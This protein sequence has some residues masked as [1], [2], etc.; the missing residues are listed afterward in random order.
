VHAEA[1]RKTSFVLRSSAVRKNRQISQSE[2]RVAARNR[3]F[4]T[5]L[6]TLRKGA[7]YTLGSTPK[8][9]LLYAKIGSA[10]VTAK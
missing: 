1:L 8:N 3:E 6:V 4:K 7:I 2:Q 10:L 5:S 9:A